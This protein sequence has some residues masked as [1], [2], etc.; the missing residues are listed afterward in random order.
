MVAL[1]T[2]ESFEPVGLG[3]QLGSS[4][5]RPGIREFA[6]SVLMFASESAAMSAVDLILHQAAKERASDI[7]FEPQKDYVRVR[8]RI[9][10]VL[11]EA[12]RLPVEVYP[13]SASRIK[14][15]AGMNIA[16]RRRP[17]DG[18]FSFRFEGRL[19]DVR[20]ATI[21]IHDGEAMV[22]RLLN[23]ES[24]LLEL[25]DLGLRPETLQ[26]VRQL[27][28]APYG[29][30]LVSGA[31]GAG[32]TTTL[33]ACLNELDRTEKNIITIEDPVEYQLAGAKQIQVNPSLGITFVSG[34]RAALR[35]DPDVILI[36]EIR[37]QETA[38]IAV[39]AALTGHLVLAS[40]H[41]NNSAGALLRLV[42]LGVDPVLVA[43]TLLGSI[44]QNLVRRNCPHCLRSY[45]TSAEEA[46]AYRREI[47]EEGAG[48]LKGAGCTYC[49]GTGYC[50][51]FGVFEVLPGEEQLQSLLLSH[52]TASKIRAQAINSGMVSQ[53]KD[54]MLK[55]K[56]GITTPGEVLRTVH[57]CD[58][59]TANPY[60]VLSQKVCSND[61]D[62]SFS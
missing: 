48:F 59:W 22:L 32:K 10:G 38:E 4:P 52:A 34:L 23:R 30:I 31:S 37:D 20:V 2:V 28:K 15:M 33:Y 56:A 47:G 14:I 43:S 60:S 35:L 29:V 62:S 46:L 7:H 21:Q 41:G 39:R 5:S 44:S 61:R 8:Y 19:L 57:P 45:R 54:G 51:R 36:G 6:D 3:H 11:T 16:E 27:L 18:G 53:Q 17:Q 9:D 50:G 42:E 40:I 55:A 12:C 49:S 1:R 58:I 24:G 13:R 26:V 25:G